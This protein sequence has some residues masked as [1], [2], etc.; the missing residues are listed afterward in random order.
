[1]SMK[2]NDLVVQVEKMEMILADQESLLQFLSEETD[3]VNELLEEISDHIDRKLV[4]Q[5]LLLDT[6]VELAEEKFSIFEAM[7]KLDH[8]DLLILVEAQSGRRDSIPGL[9]QYATALKSIVDNA[10][11]T[12]EV[13]VF[14]KDDE[15]GDAYSNQ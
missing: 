15:G 11:L 5:T 14:D 3:S 1:M 2:L 7:L 9:I 12:T 4:L 8:L 6:D 13:P 10:M